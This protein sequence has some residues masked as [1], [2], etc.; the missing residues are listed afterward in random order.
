MQ[1]YQGYVPA[2][3]AENLHGSTF[4][5]ITASVGK[6]EVSRGIE[7]PAEE[8]FKSS[9]MQYYK[10]PR[11]KIMANPLA[12]EAAYISEEVE[13]PLSELEKFWG[14]GQNAGISQDKQ[15]NNKKHWAET[16]KSKKK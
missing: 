10:N 1:G 9:N 8:R 5:K 11:D 4:G 12:P 13:I 6:G 14:A 16:I 15:L 3:A 7:N 2:V